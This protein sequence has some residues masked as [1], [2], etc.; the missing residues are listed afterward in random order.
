M[1]KIMI[2]ILIFFYM[3]L[4]YV[5]KSQS[6]YMYPCA[7]IIIDSKQ[8]PGHVTCPLQVRTGSAYAEASML[9]YSALFNI[10]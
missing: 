10:R 1:N 2:A 8:A 4:I 3:L 5:C 7:N 9:L 6:L